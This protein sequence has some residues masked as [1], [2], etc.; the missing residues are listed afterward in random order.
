VALNCDNRL[1]PVSSF[2][3]IRSSMQGRRLHN[4]LLNWW[5]KSLDSPSMLCIY[6]FY[7]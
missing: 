6:L 7:L 1:G 3:S 4:S 2:H 5:K